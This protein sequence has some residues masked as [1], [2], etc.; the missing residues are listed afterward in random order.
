MFLRGFTNSN[1]PGMPIRLCCAPFLSEPPT[2]SESKS[3]WSRSSTRSPSAARSS[4]CAASNVR[5]ACLC[6]AEIRV[7]KLHIVSDC[8]K[9]AVR[10]LNDDAGLVCSGGGRVSCFTVQ[11]TVIFEYPA[12][13]RSTAGIIIHLSRGFRA[14]LKTRAK[15]L[16]AAA[17]ELFLRESCP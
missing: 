10:L 16:R 12:V 11:M 2:Y 3:D 5:F 13:S 17:A 8:V 14:V 15:L 1:F 7:T 9:R 4:A 6:S